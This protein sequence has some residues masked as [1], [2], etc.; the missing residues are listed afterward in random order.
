MTIPYI[1]IKGIES[2]FQPSLLQFGIDIM[3][4]YEYKTNINFKKKAICILKVLNRH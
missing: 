3:F 1:Y 2:T 4:A